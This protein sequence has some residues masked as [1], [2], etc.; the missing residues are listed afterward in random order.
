MIN[1][2]QPHPYQ[3][4]HTPSFRYNK[5]MMP[6]YMPYF[7]TSYPAI[8]I[9]IINDMRLCSITL[10]TN[11]SGHRILQQYFDVPNIVTAAAIKI[12]PSTFICHVTVQSALRP[13]HDWYLLLKLYNH[14]FWIS[15]I[16]IKT[17]DVVIESRQGT[18]ITIN[19]SIFAFQWLR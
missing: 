2:L 17:W 8:V 19:F 9:I 6:I 11:N 13:H 1:L 15:S 12:I 10:Y 5:F 7:P 18:T 16:V 3:F 4:L 14:D